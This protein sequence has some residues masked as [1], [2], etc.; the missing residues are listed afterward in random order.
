MVTGPHVVL[1]K[2]HHRLIFLLKTSGL[3]KEI[4]ARYLGVMPAK[5]R[6]WLPDPKGPRNP[7]QIPPVR[8]QQLESVHRLDVRP[9]ARVVEIGADEIA[10]VMRR[11]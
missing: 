7:E 5:V 10:V 9:G 2:A 1:T 3:R 6:D 4:L 8:A 11:A